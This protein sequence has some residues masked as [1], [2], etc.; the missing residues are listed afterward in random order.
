MYHTD[1]MQH[2][3]LISSSNILDGKF[4]F[5]IQFLPHAMPYT[6]PLMEP[7]NPASVLAPSQ[8]ENYVCVE[9]IKAGGEV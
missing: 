8:Y 9:Q 4:G 7:I 5:Q 1:S 3:K 6:S 2:K